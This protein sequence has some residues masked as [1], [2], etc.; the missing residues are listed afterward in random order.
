MSIIFIMT[1]RGRISAIGFPAA[2][3]E[4]DE[5]F[6]NGPLCYDFGPVRLRVIENRLGPDW[7]EYDQTYGRAYGVVT[8]NAAI[9]VCLGTSQAT[10]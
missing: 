4:S 9:V 1:F 8:W 2:D 3:E 7:T 10:L 6:E 5:D